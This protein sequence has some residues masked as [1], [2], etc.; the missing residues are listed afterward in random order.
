V[1]LL[2]QAKEL[3]V[4]LSDDSFSN[5]QKLAK[6]GIEVAWD[7]RTLCDPYGVVGP[8]LKVDLDAALEKVEAIKASRAAALDAGTTVAPEGKKLA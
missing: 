6:L 7:G 1:R 4:G 3:G 5:C 2:L 8:D